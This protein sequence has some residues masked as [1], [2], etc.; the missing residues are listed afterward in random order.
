MVQES[1]GGSVLLAWLLVLAAS[2]STIVGAAL[3]IL[4]GGYL[5]MSKRAVSA[6][7]GLASGVMLFVAV[8]ELHAKSVEHFVLGNASEAH[9][10]SLACV[11]FFVGAAFI[12]LS[13]IFLDMF[14]SK[15]DEQFEMNGAL[16]AKHSRDVS[17]THEKTDDSHEHSNPEPTC[18]SKGSGETKDLE[19][20]TTVDSADVAVGVRHSSEEVRVFYRIGVKACIAVVLHNFPEGL[21]SFVTTIA[22]ARSGIGITFGIIL[23]NIPEGLCVAGPLY[24]AT[25]SP[26]VALAWASLSALAE[27]TGGLIGQIV[28]WSAGTTG[29]P[30]T[31]FGFMFGVVNGI[32]VMVTATE[33]LPMSSS[34]D[35]THGRH[36]TSLSFLAGA[37]IIAVTL[38]A[39]KF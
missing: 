20:G 3:V 8:A 33:L 34:L 22:E 24:L 2:L 4:S 9:A 32:I 5:A 29:V 30:G 21:A 11:S 23:H 13:N 39:E 6:C 19:H 31:A 38:V 10:Y 12:V 37:A 25:R 17:D 16:E 26:W 27:L 18:D 15:E 7:L 35:P 36:Y 1:E 28:L 14:L